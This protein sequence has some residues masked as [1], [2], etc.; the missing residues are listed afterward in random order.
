M[1][2]QIDVSILEKGDYLS[3][4]ELEKEFGLSR[5]LA[6]YQLKMVTLIDRIQKTSQTTEKNLFCRCVSGG[7]QVMTDSQAL[8]YK[9]NHHELSIKKLYRVSRDTQKIDPGNLSKEEIHRHDTEINKQ[10]RIVQSLRRERRS[11]KPTPYTK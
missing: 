10:S 8:S 1:N 2:E 5:D 11:L 7:I 9:S 6:D 4:E 3:P